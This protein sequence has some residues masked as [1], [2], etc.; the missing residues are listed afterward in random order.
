MNLYI[1]A[2]LIICAVGIKFCFK[3]GFEDYMSPAKTG[4][5]KGIFVII[6]LY[7][8]ARQYISV[9]YAENK[10][11]FDVLYF[12]GQLMVVMFLFYSGYGIA[13]SVSKKDG[14][15]KKLPKQ[16]ILKVWLDFAIAV[17]LFFL[18][19]LALD[20]N[21]GLERVLLS[22]IGIKSLGNSNW[23]IFVIIILYV[24]T[25]IA[26]G[27]TGGKK[28]FLAGV[29]LMTVLSGA[30]TAVLWYFFREQ[31]WWYDTVMCYPLGMWYYIAKPYIDKKLLPSFG[32][33]LVAVA[34]CVTAFLL[35]RSVYKE[36]D[37]IA[38]FIFMAMIFAIG[39]ALISMRIS[40][41]NGVL[42]WFGSRVFGVYILQRIPMII[43]QHFGCNDSPIVFTAVCFAITIV[44]AE[45]FERSTG[46]LDELLHITPKK[47]KK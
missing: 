6:V 25:V 31:N 29:I 38:A 14:Y 9:P 3:N 1:I 28:H 5:I 23:F 2:L 16:R 43:L 20:K 22:L 37:S 30:A 46:K 15:V 17:M 27:I 24:L 18:L 44:M 7:S 34:V 35:L 39:T 36:K 19:S 40:I 41:N 42:R 10:L 11:Y 21:Y 45:V 47:L 4:A 26:F 12:L 32:K 8:H 33:W 13:V